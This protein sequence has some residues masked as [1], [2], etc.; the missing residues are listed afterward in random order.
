M[1]VLLIIL[2][3]LW[4]VPVLWLIAA[5]LLVCIQR[6]RYRSKTGVS[7]VIQERV[8]T[9]ICSCPELVFNFSVVGVTESHYFEAEV[10]EGTAHLNMN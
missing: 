9:S 4:F 7:I 1:S 3:A 5:F 2:M 8:G 10:L 6:H